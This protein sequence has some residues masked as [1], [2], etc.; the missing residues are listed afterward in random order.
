MIKTDVIILG[1]GISGLVLST[2]LT[3]GKISHVILDR[4]Q[5]QKPMALAETL[6]PSAMGLLEELD[7]ISVFTQTA[8]KKTYG[9]HAL[10]GSSQL[11]TVDFFYSNPY[12]YGLKLNKQATLDSLREKVAKSICSYHQLN[13]IEF[14]EKEVLVKISQQNGETIIEGKWII[15]ATGRNRALL[16]VL[17][18]PVQ[19]Y[20]DLMAFSCHLPITKHHSLIHEVYTESFAHGWGIVSALSEDK[21]VMTL[22][23][24]KSNGMHQE[25]TQYDYW[26]TI[27]ADT[28]YLKDFLA[29]KA[30]DQIIGKKAN[31]SASTSFSGSNWI[32]IGDAAFTFDPLSS[33]GITNAVYTAKK[34]FDLISTS[35]YNSSQHQ[36]DLKAIFKAYLNSKNGMYQS[37]TRWREED[38]WKDLMEVGNLNLV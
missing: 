26:K 15:D 20:D 36:N 6:P 10:W 23:T 5:K 34:A 38:F 27:L 12:K 24:R 29:E 30:P 16:N 21:Q 14:S 7:L 37:E 35:A 28:H 11:Q 8:V 25:L 4:I 13:T 17:K 3:R 22:F 31:S 32:A 33:H 9:Y 1:S 2:L 18:I 19:E